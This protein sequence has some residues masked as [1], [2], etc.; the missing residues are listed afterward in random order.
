MDKRNGFIL[1]TAII[2][3]VFLILAILLSVPRSIKRTTLIIN[4][5]DSAG[6]IA[7]KLADKGLIRST[8]V[9]RLTATITR[10]DRELKPGRYIFETESNAFIALDKISSGDYELISI[11]IPEGLSLDKTLTKVSNSLD[12][13]FGELKDLATNPLICNKL[14]GINVNTLEGFLYPETYHFEENTSALQVLTVMV[15]LAKKEFRKV[16]IGSINY[17]DYYQ[18]LILASI[19]ELEAKDS[20]EMPIIADVYIKRLQKGIKLGASPTVQYLLEQEGKRRKFLYYKDT[21]IESPYNTYLNYGLPPTP[22]CS[23]SANAIR[24]VIKPTRTDYLYFFAD[25]NGKHIFTKS[26]QEHLNMRK[27]HKMKGNR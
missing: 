14:T 8:F 20:S 9:F 15:N 2:L 25:G 17:L 4:K 24:A 27:Q 7:K 12:I 21:E 1:T 22:I 23:P 3:A 19:V 18:S 26:Y 6:L 13:P 5:G 11:T 16:E 10:K